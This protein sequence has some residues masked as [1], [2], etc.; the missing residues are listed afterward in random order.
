[1]RSQPR[2]WRSTPF[3][4]LPVLAA[5]PAAAPV[6]PAVVGVAPVTQSTPVAV[7]DAAFPLPEARFGAPEAGD[8]FG[9]LPALT[10]PAREYVGRHIRDGRTAARA[11]K[12]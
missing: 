8:P 6:S 3:L 12:R 5:A 11:L 9:P 2:S 1:M 7:L 4:A 10:E